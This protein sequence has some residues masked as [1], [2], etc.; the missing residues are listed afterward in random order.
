MSLKSMQI[1]DVQKTLKC[2]FSIKFWCQNSRIYC[3]ISFVHP[4]EDLIQSVIFIYALKYNACYYV[5]QD[6][7]PPCC[8]VIDFFFSAHHWCQSVNNAL[9]HLVKIS[10]PSHG[11]SALFAQILFFYFLSSRR[12]RKRADKQTAA[13]QRS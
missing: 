10:N 8:C 4:I 5:G 13:H 2:N 6:A 1:N 9:Y 3:T 11:Y 12:K 7:E